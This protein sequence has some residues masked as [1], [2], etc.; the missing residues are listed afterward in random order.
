MRYFVFCAGNSYNKTAIDNAV[1]A[2][3]ILRCKW[4]ND[5][6]VT[7]IYDG[8]EITIDSNDGNNTSIY[9]ED[10]DMYRLISS[11]MAFTRELTKLEFK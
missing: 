7:G 5:A 2:V 8:S 3:E 6:T 10:E 4:V 1:K 9:M 11:C